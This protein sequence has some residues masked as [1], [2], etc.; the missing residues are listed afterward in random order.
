MTDGRYFLVTLLFKKCSPLFKNSNKKIFLN[1]GN[2][3]I[4]KSDHVINIRISL[5][6]R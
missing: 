4:Y 2:N 1:C 5:L 6:S 3:Y